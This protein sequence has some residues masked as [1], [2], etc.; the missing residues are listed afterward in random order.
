MAPG[1]VCRWA[2]HGDCTRRSMPRLPATLSVPIASRLVRDENW[3][4]GPAPASGIRAG[5]PDRHRDADAQS[6][7]AAETLHADRCTRT[8]ATRTDARGP[9]HADR[10]DADRCTRDPC[11][12]GP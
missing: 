5:T 2:G 12:A 11:T 1:L 8:D 9:M 3:P 7:C 10:C 4:A 6:P